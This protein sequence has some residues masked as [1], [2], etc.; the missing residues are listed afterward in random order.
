MLKAVQAFAAI[1]LAC[2]AWIPITHGQ[3]VSLA[4]TTN[5][6]KRDGQADAL[7]PKGSHR[8]KGDWEFL[9]EYFARPLNDHN[10]GS[11]WDSSRSLGTFWNVEG[12]NNF[13]KQAA[14]GK[15]PD[16]KSDI[17]NRCVL[18]FYYPGY[19]KELGNDSEIT[20]IYAF[21][22]RP[23]AVAPLCGSVDAPDSYKDF[24]RASEEENKDK[25]DSLVF[26]SYY[27]KDPDATDI[28]YVVRSVSRHAQNT[29]P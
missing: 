12:I 29:T 13:P 2:V 22:D 14:F 28:Y 21:Y 6:D 26:R 15:E 8:Q 10:L 16:A 4:D 3:D 17:T 19:W 7:M 11:G 1:S 23:L 20:D 18:V 25:V 5:L 9:Q 27:S 24:P